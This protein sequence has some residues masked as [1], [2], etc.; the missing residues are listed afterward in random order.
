M[1][2]TYQK[3]QKPFNERTIAT[4]VEEIQNGTSSIYRASK[5]YHMSISMLRRR[6]LEANGKL[7]RQKQGHKTDLPPEVEEELNLYQTPTFQ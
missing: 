4:A 3:K 5:R 6:V 2:R 7:T 1:A